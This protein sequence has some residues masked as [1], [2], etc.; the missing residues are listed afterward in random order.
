M[1]TRRLKSQ[2]S[3]L[4]TFSNTLLRKFMPHLIEAYDFEESSNLLVRDEFGL[5]KIIIAVSDVGKVNNIHFS[6]SSNI[7]ENIYVVC[8][9]RSSQSTIYQVLLYGNDTFHFCLRSAAGLLTATA[10]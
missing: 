8:V 5:H 1:I 9:N 7:N 2:I 3:Q 10:M 4:R 6:V